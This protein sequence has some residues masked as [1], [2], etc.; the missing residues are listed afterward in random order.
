MLITDSGASRSGI[1]AIRITDSGHGDQRFRS[2]GSLIP[3]IP[4]KDS[5][6]PDRS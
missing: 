5:G 2:S 4:I 1:P 3:A 6:Q